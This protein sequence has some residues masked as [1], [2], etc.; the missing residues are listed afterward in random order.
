MSS[1]FLILFIVIV[2]SINVNAQSAWKKLDNTN[3][4]LPSNVI[5][6]L[7]SD[8][9]GNVWVGTD[10]G[11]SKYDGTN[12]TTYNT[13]NSPILSDN[14]R[15]IV[16][17]KQGKKWINFNT[18]H[19]L[20]FNIFDD[21]KWDSLVLTATPY[22]MNSIPEISIYDFSK[23][24]SSDLGLINSIS[25]SNVGIRFPFLNILKHYDP[26]LN[27]KKEVDISNY[28]KPFYATSNN[29]LLKNGKL[30]ISIKQGLP[31]TT[32]IRFSIDAFT[33]NGKILA[34]SIVYKPGNISMEISFSLAG[35]EFNWK[36]KQTLTIDDI[37]IVPNSSDIISRD[38]IILGYSITELQIPSTIINDIYFD[39]NNQLSSILTEDNVFKKI[40]N[41]WTIVNDFKNLFSSSDIN[42]I[43]FDNLGYQWYATNKGLFKYDNLKW[44]TIDNSL[45]VND[46][47]FDKNGVNWI[48]SNKGLYNL[49]GNTK[50]LI[51]PPNNQIINVKNLKIDRYGNKWGLSDNNLFQ[52]DNV[53]WT[54][55][56]SVNSELN[57][58]YFSDLLIDKNNN[59][60]I[61]YYYWPQE[62]HGIS[63]LQ[64]TGKSD[65]CNLS[66]D[67]VINATYN[68]NCTILLNSLKKDKKNRFHWM[69]SKNMNTDYVDLQVN[70]DSILIK[71][72]GN[73]YLKIVDSVCTTISNTIQSVDTIL[74]AL[75]ICMVTTTNNHNLVVWE[76]IN[77]TYVNKYRIYRQS[78]LNSNYELVHEQS[79]KENS[80]WI[81]INSSNQIERYKLSILDACGRETELSENHTTILL[82]SN[83]GSNSTVNLAWNPYEGFSYKNFEIWRSTNGIT[84]NLLS[85]VANNTYAYI[86]NNPPATGYYQIRIVNP[87]TCNP[88]VRNISSVISNTV[89]KNGKIINVASLEDK[90]TKIVSFR[91][92]PNPNQGVFNIENVQPNTIF[93]LFDLNG[94]KV[95]EQI[96][97]NTSLEVTLGQHINKGIYF[98]QATYQGNILGLE[99]LVIE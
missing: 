99:K 33:K 85:T 50:K 23:L 73:Y 72:A 90:L 97:T 63:I 5:N 21:V 68:D 13:K 8:S 41:N 44:E 48:C 83:L 6:C 46:V 47:V 89:D 65:L 14:I 37:T 94:R 81:D 79:K 54:I 69:Y 88:S 42:K 67:K 26:T 66:K 91:I 17:D 74:A 55:Y 9:I 12:W 15:K 30:R 71:D 34:D 1:K 60:W 31:H 87:T 95:H 10:K 32:I 70:K 19:D 35:Y 77:N 18:S 45:L 16:I 78:K 53:N 51:S 92:F 28:P 64:G 93:S 29:V 40:N 49:I 38:K 86:D 7:V 11:L 62:Y 82:S 76:N 2:L 56:D 27:L 59:K 25:K 24:S 4:G 61:S 52:F 75:P 84:F 96:S 22:D 20:K 57:G 39:N 58:D 98:L 3:S 43:R 36:D 80:T